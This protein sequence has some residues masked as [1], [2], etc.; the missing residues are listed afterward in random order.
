MKANLDRILRLLD[1]PL[2]WLELA[3]MVITLVCVVAMVAAVVMD[4][5]SYHD[6]GDVKSRTRSRVATGTMALFFVLLFLLIRLEVGAVRIPLLTLRII[7]LLAGLLIMI[8]GCAVG[9]A[10]RFNLG[11]NWANQITVYQDQ[12]LVTRGAYRYVRH[13]LYASLIWMSYG[14]GLVY[15]NVSAI[16]ATTLVFVPMMVM[17]ARREEKVLMREFPGYADYRRRVNMFFPWV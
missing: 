13:P 4:I 9:I 11:K 10:G 5:M 1:T 8:A 16:L 12:E 2:G 3:A 7:I 17:R 6:R 15:A 14:A